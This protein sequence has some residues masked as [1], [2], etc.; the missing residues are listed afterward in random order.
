MAVVP[1]RRTLIRDLYFGG[2]P[3][4]LRFRS[5]LLIFDLVLI[6]FFIDSPFLA[7]TPL[8]LTID[9][10]IAAI[11]ALD[12]A[13]RAWAYGN[14]GR[15]LLRPIVI[16]DV[17]VLLSLLFPALGVN[18]AF[19]RILR[20]YSLM[21]SPQFWTTIVGGRWS[22]TTTEDTTKAIANLFIFI[23]I[24]TGFVHST[25][26]A[27]SPDINSYFDS[28]YFTVSSLTTTGYGDITLPGPWG[29][30]L[31]IIIM[32]VGISLFVRLAQVI[33]RPNKIV[34]PCSDCGL[35]R[36]DPDA[37]HCKA[38]GAQLRIAHDND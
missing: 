17:V 5:R 33:L 2:S 28:L 20:A 34:H 1:L 19:L 24:M 16:A 37:V 6:A 32:V 8:V 22:G 15:W 10:V 18:L 4:A 30:L 23:F 38:C 12:L 26:A 25:F 11:L 13:L 21:N 36:H 7:R 9:Y 27:R 29:R 3:R 14:I 35:R 31:S